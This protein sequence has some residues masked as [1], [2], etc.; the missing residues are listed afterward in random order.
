GRRRR[1]GRGAERTVGLRTRAERAR[2]HGRRGRGLVEQ[3]R[4]GRRILVVQAAAHRRGAL[5]RGGRVE[6]AGGG[7][8]AVGIGA[9]A[10][11]RGALAEGVGR[12]ARGRGIRPFGVGAHVVGRVVVVA[13]GLEIAVAGG[14]VLQLAE[15]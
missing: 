1:T 12:L 3:D 15:V 11:G 4:A 14:G 10:M 5:A 7:V 6:A 9:A 13:G 8:L 2:A